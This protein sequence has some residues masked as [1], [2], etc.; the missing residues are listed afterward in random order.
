MIGTPGEEFEGHLERVHIT[1]DTLC[2]QN[3]SH[4]ALY[5]SQLELGFHVWCLAEHP[6]SKS[7]E[8][9]KPTV[10]YLLSSR[11]GS[12]PLADRSGKDV[13]DSRACT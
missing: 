10:T 13:D 1:H 6:I 11:R 2:S 3:G 9:T 12:V 5:E 8:C 7:S 4:S